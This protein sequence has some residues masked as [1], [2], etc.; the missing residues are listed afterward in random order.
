MLR[1]LTSP[2]N[3]SRASRTA[4]LPVS[5]D[6]PLASDPL[7]WNFIAKMIHPDL[8]NHL[9][10]QHS[11]PAWHYRKL[12]AGSKSASHRKVKRGRTRP[13]G[14]QERGAKR[15]SIA[16][17]RH[18][19]PCRSAYLSAQKGDMPK[20]THLRSG[21]PT[22]SLSRTG[23]THKCARPNAWHRI[24]VGSC[25]STRRA[26]AIALNEPRQFNCNLVIPYVTLGIE[27][28]A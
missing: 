27:G 4:F 15:T 12:D 10:Y 22:R 25:E 20:R 16:R 5:G 11:L 17:F 23:Q 28:M 19:N 1:A 9:Q 13:A 21:Q 2:V 3:A 26:H 24:S 8:H 6:R 7:D 18:N 14:E